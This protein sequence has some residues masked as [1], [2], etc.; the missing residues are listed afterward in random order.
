[1]SGTAINTSAHHTAVTT[2]IGTRRML[3]AYTVN[4]TA[5]TAKPINCRPGAR[6]MAHSLA[7]TVPARSRTVM[8]AHDSTTTAS[9]AAG[10][11]AVGTPI[12][13]A[14]RL[15]WL[16]LLPAASRDP[17]RLQIRTGRALW[18]T[19]HHPQTGW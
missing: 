13:R 8:A 14:H 19:G 7:N 15:T 11:A 2:V 17:R 4:S 10:A 16:P 9:V 3:I 5:C 6:R 18:F 12:S 1:M